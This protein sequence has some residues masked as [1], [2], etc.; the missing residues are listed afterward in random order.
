MLIR[1]KNTRGGLGLIKKTVQAETSMKM[2]GR[3][4][5]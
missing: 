2:N 4:G 5:I 3:S 1:I